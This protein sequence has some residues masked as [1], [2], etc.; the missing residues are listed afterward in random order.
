MTSGLKAGFALAVYPLS[1]FTI[2]TD[3]KGLV[4]GDISIPS[5]DRKIPGYWAMPEGKGPFPTVVVV[6]EIFG[7]HEHIRDLCRRLAKKGFLAVAPYLYS[8]QGDV[9][10]MKEVNDII[11][12]VIFKVIRSE[13]NQDL[14]ATIKFAEASKKADANRLSM[15]GFCWGGATTWLYAARNPQLKAGAAWYGPLT[16]RIAGQESP[17]T[18]APMLKVPVLGLYG[19]KDDHISQASIK[20]MEEALKKGTSGSKIIVYP[21]AGHG[22]NADYR[23]SYVRKD[24]D[25]AWARMLDWFKT[26]HAT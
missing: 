10:H 5:F 21:D 11:N 13:V 16:A 2:S 26:H 24:A 15:T 23:D 6:H 18:I 14:D 1:A 4:A 7:L 25:G 8:R 20:E 3:A 9:M 12:K 22:F 17:I 19:A